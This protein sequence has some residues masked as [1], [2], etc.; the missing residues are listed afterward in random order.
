MA[1]A[2]ASL[3]SLPRSHDHLAARFP[4][5]TPMKATALSATALVVVV[6]ALAR[7]EDELYDCRDQMIAVE[8]VHTQSVLSSAPAHTPSSMSSAAV[9]G[10]LAQY[11]FADAA[12]GAA[13]VRDAEVR[14]VV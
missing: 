4:R 6:A 14:M 2:R 5:I 8:R 9:D 1:F 7:A 3:I 11:T 10:F 13:F 12:A